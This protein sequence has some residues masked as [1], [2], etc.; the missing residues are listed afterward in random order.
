MDRPLLRVYVAPVDG[1]SHR[2]DA[3][4]EL[5]EPRASATNG[6]E[7]E[8]RTPAGPASATPPPARSWR[9][10]WQRMIATRWSRLAWAAGALVVVGSAIALTVVL[11]TTPRPDETLHVTAAEPDDLVRGLV[12]REASR[13]HIADSTLRSYGSFLGLEIWSG[14]DGFGS[15][16]ILSVNRANDTLSDLRCAPHPAELFIDIASFGDDYDGLPGEGLIRFIHRGDT[17][18]AYVHL[19]PGTD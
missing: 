13:A 14:T 2:S 5:S 18:D 12:A 3:D 9:S 15:P 16:C 6:P 8:S 19:M 4:R 17:V 10:L 11:S 7:P 1:S